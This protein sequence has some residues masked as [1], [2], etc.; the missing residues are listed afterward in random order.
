MSED[1]DKLCPWCG[2]DLPGEARTV[3]EVPPLRFRYSLG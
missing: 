1:N 2:G 3:C